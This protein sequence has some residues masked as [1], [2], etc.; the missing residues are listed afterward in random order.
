M[1]KR[2]RFVRVTEESKALKSLRLNSGLSQRELAKLMVV[3][4]TKIAHAENGRAYIRRP[5]VELFIS[6]LKLS[7]E[8]WDE[9]VGKSKCDEEL[10]EECRRLIGKAS[11]EKLRV[12]HGLL[13]AF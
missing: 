2:S 5:Y 4:Q 12:L 1:A 10:R 13:L 8:D 3:T 11:D 6:R 7:W 9:L